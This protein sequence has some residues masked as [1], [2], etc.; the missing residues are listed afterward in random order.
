MCNHIRYGTKWLQSFI[1]RDRY[2]NRLI[3]S[4]DK[5]ECANFKKHTSV[6]SFFFWDDIRCVHNNI[7]KVFSR[8]M[9][10]NALRYSWNIYTSQTRS[11][12]KVCYRSAENIFC[13]DL[14]TEQYLLC[15]Y[16]CINNCIL[17]KDYDANLCTCI[18]YG[19]ILV[20]TWP[21]NPCY[22]LLISWKG[23]CFWYHRNKNT[24]TIKAFDVRDIFESTSM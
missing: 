14:L 6:Y 10:I 9:S 2:I 24:K 5:G 7:K 11:E 19:W 22:Q 18:T 4:K 21:C 16:S 23:S 15:S 13:I 1:H 12:R 8:S 3:L 17:S 20:S